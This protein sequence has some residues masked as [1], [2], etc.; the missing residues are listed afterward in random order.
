MESPASL[1]VI[2]EA[3][4]KDPGESGSFGCVS[5]EVDNN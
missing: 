2:D 4:L 1:I 3:Q 5:M